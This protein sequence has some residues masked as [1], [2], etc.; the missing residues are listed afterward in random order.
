MVTRYPVTPPVSKLQLVKRYLVPQ[1][2]PTPNPRLTALR[3]KTS[4]QLYAARV[5]IL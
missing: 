1:V 5:N 3:G 4:G 2:V